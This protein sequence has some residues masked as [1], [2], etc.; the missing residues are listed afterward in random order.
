MDFLS[1]LSLV[2]MGG[3][4]TI[5]NLNLG[6]DNPPLLLGWVIMHRLLLTPIREL[7]RKGKTKL[8][9]SF[10][11]SIS[12]TQKLKA[13]QREDEIWATNIHTDNLTNSNL[14]QDNPF[15]QLLEI[16][17]G[18]FTLTRKRLLDPT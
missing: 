18:P 7:M 6:N 8:G 5:D 2:K 12:A 9:V 11:D 10:N 3:D 16:F 4:M 1:D 14:R 13:I 15:N 17:Q